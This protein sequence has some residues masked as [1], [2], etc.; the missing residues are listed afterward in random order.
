M[1]HLGTAG[2]FG[3]LV[4]LVTD[5][6]ARP[7]IVYGAALAAAAVGAT[8]A[9]LIAARLAANLGRRTLMSVAAL[10]AAL[11]VLVA[12][13]SRSMDSGLVRGLD[14]QRWRSGGTMLAGSVAASSS[15]CAERSARSC[16]DPSRSITRTAFV[17]GA[18]L[19]GAIANATS[20]RW[21]FAV[22]ASFHLLGAV[23]LTRAFRY[24]PTSSTPR[25]RA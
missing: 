8:L 10:L 12:G 20:I 3:L 24:E 14:V 11:S 22:S 5:V 4:L 19:A 7:G 25:H 18:L 16:G 17:V 6:L 2:A 23:L 21:A 9:S 13:S 15:V 1:F